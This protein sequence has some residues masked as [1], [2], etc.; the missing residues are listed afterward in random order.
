MTALMQRIVNV[1]HVCVLAMLRI[2]V[3][4]DTVPPEVT[5]AVIEAEKSNDTSLKLVSAPP[6]TCYLYSTVKVLQALP[7]ICNRRRGAAFNNRTIRRVHRMFPLQS[8][9]N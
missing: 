6:G 1:R 2:R 8:G 4:C 5:E 9:R 3:Y 7:E